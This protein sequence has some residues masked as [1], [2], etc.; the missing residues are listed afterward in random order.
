MV[1]G[2]ATRNDR[3]LSRNTADIDGSE[4]YVVGYRPNRT[5]IAQPFPSL[6]PS[7]R[8]GL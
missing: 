2:I 5:D 4:L 3:V 6:R 1:G 7:H 8:P